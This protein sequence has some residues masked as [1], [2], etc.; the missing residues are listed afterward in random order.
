MSDSGSDSNHHEFD[1]L[2]SDASTVAFSDNDLDDWFSDTSSH[3][4]V[5]DFLATWTCQLCEIVPPMEAAERLC[6]KWIEDNEC[7][8][9]DD[10]SD[11]WRIYLLC[12]SCHKIAHLQCL[13]EHGHASHAMLENVL[14]DGEYNCI[15]CHVVN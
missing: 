2:G 8:L 11:I 14:N 7:L 5:E 1:D 4:T 13:L 3:G 9:V 6:Q 10:T 15:D 12:R